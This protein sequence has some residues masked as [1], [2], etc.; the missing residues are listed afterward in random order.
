MAKYLA[1]NLEI[2]IFGD[3]KQIFSEVAKIAMC[4]AS[5]VERHTV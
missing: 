4:L 2:A 5:P 3:V 1:R